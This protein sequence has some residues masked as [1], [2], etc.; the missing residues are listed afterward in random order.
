MGLEVLFCPINLFHLGVVIGV[1]RFHTEN[2]AQIFASSVVGRKYIRFGFVKRAMSRRY[3][4]FTSILSLILLKHKH[5]APKQ[6]SNKE[7]LTIIFLHSW[8]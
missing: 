8:R 3:R 4:Y 6:E 2:A 5:N 1:S 7:A